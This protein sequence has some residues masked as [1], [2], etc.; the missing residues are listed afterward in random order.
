MLDVQDLC[1]S[2][3]ERPAEDIIEFVHSTAKFSVI[4][5]P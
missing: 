1:G 4:T 5:L 3:V 2:L